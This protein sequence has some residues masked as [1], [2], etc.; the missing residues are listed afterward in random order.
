MEKIQK[1]FGFLVMDKGH[2]FDIEGE[3]TGEGCIFK[4][5]EAFASGEGICYVG[6]Y[7]LEYIQENL[8]DLQA[9][10]ENGEMTD[11]EYRLERERII[12][13]GGET[14]Q[15]IIDQVREAW[16]DEYLLTDKQVEYFAEDV[17]A[18]AEWACIATYLAE[19]YELDDCIEYDGIKNGGIFSLLQYTAVMSGMTPK[20]FKESQK[21][22]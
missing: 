21:E 19:N 4:D 20:E 10:Y 2:I 22:A 14:R 8:T 15:T 1:D 13:A 5:L 16:G 3:H 17:L 11:E 6:E 9:L 18:L 7:G 12:L